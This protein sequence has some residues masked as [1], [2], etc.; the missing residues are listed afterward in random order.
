MSEAPKLLA[1]DPEQLAQ[2][3]RRAARD[4]IL[5]YQKREG[6]FPSYRKIAA[7]IGVRSTHTISRYIER[8]TA[9]GEL[10]P[11]KYRV[12]NAGQ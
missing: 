1:S 9:S 11:P 2:A 7:A 5:D 10:D 8:L 3:N 12:A 6:R 4:F